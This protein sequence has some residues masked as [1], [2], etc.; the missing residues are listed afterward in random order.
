MTHK[1]IILILVSG[2]DT[3]D[4][5]LMHQKNHPDQP[6]PYLSHEHSI[7]HQRQQGEPRCMLSGSNRC[8]RHWGLCRAGSSRP[9]VE[10]KISCNWDVLASR[11]ERGH[12][13]MSRH[14]K[15]GPCY[16]PHR[17]SCRSSVCT[18]QSTQRWRLVHRIHE[19]RH[20]SLS[21]SPAC[22]HL[23]PHADACVPNWK[24]T[25][26]LRRWIRDASRTRHLVCF[27]YPRPTDE[28]L[29]F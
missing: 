12:I 29:R 4:H 22:S 16:Q 23:P 7:L 26:V 6:A 20:T 1:F 19:L 18:D 27:S 13:F 9:G 5:T 28:Q 3:E 11:R 17:Q 14:L 8:V 10:Q 15:S 21:T 2:I 25:S 24:H